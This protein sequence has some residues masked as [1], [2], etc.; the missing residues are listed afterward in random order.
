MLYLYYNDNTVYHGYRKA[1]L[2]L[3]RKMVHYISPPTL[4]MMCTPTED[5][6]PRLFPSQLVEV[7]ASVLDNEVINHSHTHTN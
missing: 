5:N 3:M 1:S 6:V 2:T 4:M 7:L